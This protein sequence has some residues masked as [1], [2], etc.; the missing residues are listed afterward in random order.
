MTDGQ[1]YDPVTKIYSDD[2]VFKLGYGGPGFVFIKTEKWD[3]PSF[4]KP[5][6]DELSLKN[7][8]RNTELCKLTED[9]LGK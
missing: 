3:Y 9:D 1:V 6:V 2:A 4:V 7:V 8:T 5:L